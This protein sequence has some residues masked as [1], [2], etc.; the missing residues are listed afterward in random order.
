MKEVFSERLLQ[1]VNSVD[2][3]EE[4]SFKSI[5]SLIETY[6]KKTLDIQ[7]I[8]I[9]KVSNNSMSETGQS[10]NELFGNGNIPIDE[11]IEDKG[12][13][14]FSFQKKKKLW[15]T[16]LSKEKILKK[17]KEYID[18]WSGIEN[19]PNYKTFDKETKRKTSIIIPIFH[20]FR[21]N[22]IIGVV[23]FESNEYIEPT[24]IA[25]ETL[26][27]LSHII[28]KAIRLYNIKIQFQESTNR[29]LKNLKSNLETLSFKLTKPKL[30]L[31]YPDKAKDDVMG[32]LKSIIDS[33]YEKKILVCDWK[34]KAQ[35]GQITEE[36]FQDIAQS[37][38]AIYYFS[39]ADTSKNRYS[40]KD[41]SNVVFEAGLYQGRDN[42][43]NWI[44][45]REKNSE[46]IP[47]DFHNF[48]R[49]D[50]PRDSNGDLKQET[51]REELKNALNS[52]IEI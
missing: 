41:N 33:V 51:F 38:Y 15:I 26:Q 21:T 3:L 34:G 36:I 30:F 31:G 28:S 11:N 16:A 25:K 49:I 2:I 6:V 42:N 8:K 45:I 7:H 10:L 23:N 43:P 27:K 22:E 12:Q 44:L 46:E 20:D 24:K 17:T 19:I 35:P 48:R 50:V 47:F 32:C 5:I 13:M 1:F 4:S 52:M 29:S 18:L 37:Q 14:P 40:Y 39:E 9:M